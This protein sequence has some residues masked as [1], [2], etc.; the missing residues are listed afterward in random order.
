MKKVVFLLMIAVLGGC[1]THAEIKM[2]TVTKI[3]DSVYENK[4]LNYELL[5]SQPKPGVFSGGEQLALAPLE[6]AEL[7]VASASTLKELPKLIFQ[8]LPVSVKYL[9]ENPDLTL[10]IEIIAHDKKGPAYADHEFG[11]SL[12]KNLLTLGLGSSEYNI[13]ADFDAKYILEQNGNVIF[14]K[15]FK[16]KDEVDHEKGDFDSYNTLNEFTSQMLEKHLILTLHEFFKEAA[17]H[18]KA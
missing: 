14:T 15:D 6:K 4:T 2:P 13:V 5:Y 11:K 7:S 12:G 10:K 8:Q 3:H 16:V 9:T 18:V 1:T 17:I